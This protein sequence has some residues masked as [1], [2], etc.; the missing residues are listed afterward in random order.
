MAKAKKIPSGSWRC[1]S[2]DY[3]DANGK[4]HYKSFTASTKKEAEYMAAEYQI[5]KKKPTGEDITFGVALE[6]YI[7]QRTPVLSPASIR[8]YKRAVKNYD[9][10]HKV[11]I[12]D[13]TQD[14]IQEHVNNF[15]K[16]HSA[17][18]VRDN[19]ALITAVLRMY[20]P[21]FAL[22]TVLPQ[23]HRPDLYIPTDMD[24]KKVLTA[25]TGT[26][27]EVPILLAAFGPMRRGEICALRYEDIVGNRVHVCRN[28]VMDENRKYV[29]KDPK[30]YAGDR[31]IDFP[32]FVADKLDGKS[33][34]VTALNPN[35][36]TQRFNHILIKAGVPHFRFH[37][38]RHYCA[39][40]LHALGMPD[41]YIME[42][43][44]WGNDGTLKNVY[45][46]ALEDQKVK[47]NNMANEHFNNM[48]HEMQHE[49]I[50]VQ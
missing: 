46:H 49:K 48:Q 26:E 33:G 25:A 39:S 3:T 11:K 24:I 21:N 32:T 37:D 16:E 40:I 44:G 9:D 15:S 2:Y 22:N 36:I 8:E 28:M 18:S 45:R 31:F 35:M 5:N 4:R 50:K 19:H 42:R 43:G 30:S 1:Q 12:R 13:I 6:H 14:I 7:A 20:R 17:K 38:L 34:N 23:K 29:I 27:M 10:I 41:A 47:M